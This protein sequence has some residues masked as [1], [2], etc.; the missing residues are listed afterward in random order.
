MRESF[1]L[2]AFCWRIALSQLGY[3]GLDEIEL[4]CADSGNPNDAICCGVF[5]S[6][7]NGTSAVPVGAPGVLE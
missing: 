6:H 7:E 4:G 5:I 2:Y 3:S 1:W